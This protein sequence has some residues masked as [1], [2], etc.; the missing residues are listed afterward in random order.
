MFDALR[1][2]ATALERIAAAQESR[3]KILVADA[4]VHTH[5]KHLITQANALVTVSNERAAWY[6]QES[7]VLKGR[8]EALTDK[9][10]KME[11]FQ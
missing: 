4:D 9:V 2:I 3:V 1:R 6:H 10:R 11:Q 5:A 8:I 7:V